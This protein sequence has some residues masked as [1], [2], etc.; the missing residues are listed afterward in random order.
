MSRDW[1]LSQNPD[2]RES[3]L[4]AFFHYVKYGRTEFRNWQEPKWFSKAFGTQGWVWDV[5][6]FFLIL[7]NIDEQIA[8]QN[9]REILIYRYGVYKDEIKKIRRELLKSQK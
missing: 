6:K 2:V 9:Y 7:E 5:S 8:K 4:R 3:G 1:Y